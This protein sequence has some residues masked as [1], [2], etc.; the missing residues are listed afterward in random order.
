MFF[1]QK[2]SWGIHFLKD[3]LQAKYPGQGSFWQKIKLESLGCFLFHTGVE[4]DL[5]Q[6][7]S[8]RAKEKTE[9]IIGYES[10]KINREGY[11]SELMEA[12]AVEC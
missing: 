7:D 3:E 9:L 4:G 6:E 10:G 8:G 1:A 2:S 5:Y 11:L 12:K